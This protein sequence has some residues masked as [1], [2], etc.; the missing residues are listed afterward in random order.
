MRLRW[1][2]GRFADGYAHLAL[3]AALILAPA[4]EPALRCPQRLNAN[5]VCNC[6]VFFAS[7]L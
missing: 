7:P 6:A 1:G 5:S 2:S 3:S 4:Q